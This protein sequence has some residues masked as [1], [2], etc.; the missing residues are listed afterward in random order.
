MEPAPG[1]VDS[2]HQVLGQR[3]ADRSGTR[4]AGSVAAGRSRAEAA[5]R[6]PV[7]AGGRDRRGHDGGRQN[8]G[9]RFRP[10][11]GPG[12]LPCRRCSSPARARSRQPAPEGA[13][14]ALG[15]SL[16]QSRRGQYREHENVLPCRLCGDIPA[17][18]PHRQSDARVPKRRFAGCRSGSRRRSRGRCSFRGQARKLS[19]PAA[20]KRHGRFPAGFAAYPTSGG[21]KPTAGRIKER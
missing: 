10:R 8:G 6:R 17:G 3:Q 20:S 11:G 5:W 21:N 18:R 1:P 19:L 9:R 7:R 14:G 2:A 13:A 16:L 12:G 4:R 15:A